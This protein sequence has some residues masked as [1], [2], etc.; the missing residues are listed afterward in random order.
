VF[1]PN[2]GLYSQFIG[3]AAQVLIFAAS[4]DIDF[5]AHLARKFLFELA[6]HIIVVKE[7]A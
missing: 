4:G 5:I 3:S 2:L 6:D 1:Q 7:T